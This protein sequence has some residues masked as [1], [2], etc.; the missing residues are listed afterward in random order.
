MLERIIDC[1]KPENVMVFAAGL[2]VYEPEMSEPSSF[3]I[4]TSIYR[5]IA[6]AMTKPSLAPPPAGP[7]A[8]VAPVGP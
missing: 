2:N 8:P 7:V 4:V 6:I 1:G 3:F 5:A